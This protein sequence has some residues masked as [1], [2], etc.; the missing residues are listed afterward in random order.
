MLKFPKAK[1][2]PYKVR[3]KLERQLVRAFTNQKTTDEMSSFLRDLLT[4]KEIKEFANRVEVA[5]L[6][7]EGGSYLDIAKK[8]HVSTTTITRVAQ[9]LTNGHG[10]Y[11]RA[12]K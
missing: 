12:L 8:L 2:R 9:W 1:P 3:T 11:M 5:R 7:T 10:G 6:L 4:N